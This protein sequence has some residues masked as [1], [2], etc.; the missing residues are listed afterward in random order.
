MWA[1]GVIIPQ[2]LMVWGREHVGRGC[3]NTPKTVTHRLLNAVCYDKKSIFFLE[4]PPS[5]GKHTTKIKLRY[6]RLS[7]NPP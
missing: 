4:K 3:H 7:V 6:E 1:E 5:L 2:R